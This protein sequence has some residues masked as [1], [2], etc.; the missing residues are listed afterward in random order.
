MMTRT[1]LIGLAC[2]AAA[3]GGCATSVATYEPGAASGVSAS[4]AST[5]SA[6]P[7]GNVFG[8]STHHDFGSGGP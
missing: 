3:C 4:P 5:R 2:L 6:P 8:P 1:M 7:P